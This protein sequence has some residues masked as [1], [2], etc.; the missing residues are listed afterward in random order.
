[1]QKIEILLGTHNGASFLSKQIDSILIQSYANWKLVIHDDNSTDGTVNII[2]EYVKKYS[3]KII[4][5]DD[6][7]GFGNASENFSFLSEHITADYIMFCDQ[8]DVWLP[9][10]IELTLQKMMEAEKASPETPLL[11]HTDLRVV[12]TTLDVLND[13]Y[14]TYQG[15]DPKYDTL[16]RLLVQNVI[17]GCTMMINRQLAEMALPIPKDAVMH[18]WWLG[19]VASAFGEIHYID[20]ATI[21]YRQH[22]NNDT[23]ATAYSIKTILNKA[24]NLSNIDMRK[25]I[26]QAKT[27][28]DRYHSQLSEE[29]K[30]LLKDFISIEHSSWLQSKQILL[31]HKILKQDFIRNMGLLLCH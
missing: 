16:N 20:T 28:L 15:I 18:D 7:V 26:E 27:F 3:D 13:S 29:Q 21:L 12:N 30:I 17:T 11:I 2:N 10:K 19:I 6:N 9:N 14:W 31:K 1:M 23:G 25:Y 8:D 4:L 5:I 22:G 24:K